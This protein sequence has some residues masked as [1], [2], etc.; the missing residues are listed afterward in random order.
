MLSAVNL[1]RFS[2]E[3]NTGQYTWHYIFSYLHLKDCV[4]YIS[5]RIMLSQRHR[6]IPMGKGRMSIV[7]L[8][9]QVQMKEAVHVS[10]LITLHYNSIIGG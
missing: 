6:D 3:N 4:Y 5:Y 10:E 7:M 9:T 1:L 8:R 2:T